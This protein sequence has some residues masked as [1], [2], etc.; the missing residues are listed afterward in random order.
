MLPWNISKFYFIF[1]FRQRTVTRGINK[2]VKEDFKVAMEKQ[3][4]RSDEC[5]N[6]L[7]VSFLKE[8]RQLL[9]KSLAEL[10]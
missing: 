4:S 6:K 7:I 1:I 3:A 9:L 5:V 2:G 10:K 8:E